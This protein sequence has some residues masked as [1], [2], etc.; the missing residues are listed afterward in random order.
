MPFHMPYPRETLKRVIPGNMRK[1]DNTADK[2]IQII[3]HTE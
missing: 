2:A 3:G 1:A